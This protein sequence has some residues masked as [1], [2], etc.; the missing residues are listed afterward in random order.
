M[1]ATL[2]DVSLSNSAYTDLY[3]ETGIVVGTSLLIQNKTTNNIIV[4]VGASLPD[5]DNDDGVYLKPY[6]FIIVEAGE[7]GAWAIGTGDISVQS[8]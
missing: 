1:A 8:N 5:V 3:N 2:P 6:D 4:Q 7:S